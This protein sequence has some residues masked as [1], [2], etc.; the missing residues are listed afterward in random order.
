M[1]DDTKKPIVTPVTPT[2]EPI[3]FA[4]NTAYAAAFGGSADVISK[5]QAIWNSA[6]TLAPAI[7]EAAIYGTAAASIVDT[8]A[9]FAAALAAFAHKALAPKASAPVTPIANTTPVATDEIT[10]GLTA[11]ADAK[12]LTRNGKPGFSYLS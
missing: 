5:A 2:N 1:G 3:V 10:N 9:G 6:V 11:K 8:G 7:G 12:N 4:A